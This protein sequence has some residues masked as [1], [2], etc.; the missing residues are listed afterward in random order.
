MHLLIYIFSYPII[1][2][3]SLLPFRIIYILSSTFSLLL[4]NIFRYR[5]DTVRKNLKLVFPEKSSNE[6][7]KIEKDF[8]KH[9]SDIS[10]ESIKAYGMTKSEMNSRYKYENIELLHQIQK[11]SKNF[12]II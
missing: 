8:Y 6:I 10:F 1:K 4:R 12:I 5:L 9:F 11:K 2:I 7:I 3:I